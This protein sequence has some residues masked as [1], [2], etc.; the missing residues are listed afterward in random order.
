MTTKQ[1]KTP[2]RVSLAIALLATCAT[3][4]ESFAFPSPEPIRVG[5][6]EVDP[7]TGLVTLQWNSQIG[8]RYAIE[9]TTQFAIG[10]QES[11]KD[12]EANSPQTTL[13]FLPQGSSD[14]ARAKFCR[15]RMVE[16]F[17]NVEVNTK[18]TSEKKAVETTDYR[19][20]ETYAEAKSQSGKR[21]SSL[22]TA[23]DQTALL[24]GANVFG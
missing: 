21:S 5:R 9:E 3:N 23:R 4:A 16:E 11:R 18:V 19:I 12:I 6:I 1:T 10:W 15:I 24:L 14:G 20:H 13:S 22:N 2:H 7:L 8:S 17:G